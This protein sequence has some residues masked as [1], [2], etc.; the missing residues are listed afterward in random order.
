MNYQTLYYRKRKVL[1]PEVSR[2]KL[3]STLLVAEVT[4]K[5]ILTLAVLPYQTE[6][7]CEL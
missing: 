2:P 3:Q 6:H 7:R 4:A 5:D 1:C